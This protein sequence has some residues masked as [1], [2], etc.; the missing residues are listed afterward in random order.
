[1]TPSKLKEHQTLPG[2]VL[3]AWLLRTKKTWLVKCSQGAGCE[4][5]KSER[6]AVVKDAG[7][8]L[9]KTFVILTTRTWAE[10]TTVP[11][12]SSGYSLRLVT[13]SD[14]DDTDIKSQT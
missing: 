11:S 6:E 9:K 5:G 4:S 7:E 8:T 13:G 3:L 1:M 14:T 10:V 2:A 12:L